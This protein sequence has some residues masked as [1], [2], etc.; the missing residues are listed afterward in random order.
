MSQA[1]TAVFFHA[2]PDDE[3]IATGGVM[4]LIAN[5]GDR[6]VLVCAT[7][8][9][10]GLPVDGV[11]AQGSELG[12]LRTR[13]L[14]VACDALGAQ[15]VEMLGYHDSGMAG[16]AANDNPVCFAQTDVDTAARRLADLLIEENAELLTIYDSDGGYG[17]PDHIQVHRVGVRAAE[18]VEADTGH[19]PRVFETTINRD[20]IF[21]AADEFAASEG[22]GDD[23]AASP[24]AVA[25]AEAAARGEE[26]AIGRPE[27]LI[28]HAVSVVEAL[29]AKRA[30]IRAHA[31]QIRPDTWFLQMDDAVFDKVF[32]TEWFI[33]HGPGRAP[34]EPFQTELW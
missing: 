28:T 8:G 20:V 16:D 14:K 5:Q 23:E 22:D 13:E 15:R 30:A 12:D 3:A 29:P 6:V 2:H 21:R 26:F 25:A 17:H 11:A 19:G 4:R 24:L 1:R 33:E 27:S 7:N 9:E 31:S 18:M 32:G 34:D 10:L